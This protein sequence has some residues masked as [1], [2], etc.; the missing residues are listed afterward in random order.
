MA[1]AEGFGG[2]GGG[3][4]SYNSLWEQIIICIFMGKV[5]K[6]RLKV[7]IKP[8]LV[9][10]TTPPPFRNYG[11]V[12]H[13]VHPDTANAKCVSNADINKTIAEKHKV[14]KHTTKAFKVYSS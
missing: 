7:E 3:R 4:V 1:D 9:G 10:L 8:P 2:G 12:P 5:Y 6:N 14:R 13:V 11:S